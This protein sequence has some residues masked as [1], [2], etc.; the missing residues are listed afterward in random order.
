M[1]RNIDTA[2]MGSMGGLHRITPIYSVGIPCVA[3]NRHYFRV[4]PKI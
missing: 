2:C 4:F 3:N 1:D